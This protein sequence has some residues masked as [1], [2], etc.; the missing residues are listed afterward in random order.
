M[1]SRGADIVPGRQSLK[2]LFYG[3]INEE[4]RVIENGPS[5]RKLRTRC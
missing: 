4:N 3:E 5:A 2:K 1:R